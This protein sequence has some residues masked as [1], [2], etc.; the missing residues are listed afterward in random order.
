MPLLLVLAGCS[1]QKNPNFNHD[2][3]VGTGGGFEETVESHSFSVEGSIEEGSTVCLIVQDK[4]EELEGVDAVSVMSVSL[5][6]GAIDEKVRVDHNS[7]LSPNATSF[8]FKDNKIVMY[9]DDEE[10]AEW[11]EFDV[12][13][14]E[15]S[16]TESLLP[17]NNQLANIVMTDS[18]G[19]YLVTPSHFE[20]YH[21]N[22][23]DDMYLHEPVE[24]IGYDRLIRFNRANLYEGEVYSAMHVTDV[25]ERFDLVSGELTGT[26][27]LE[28]WDDW[29][30]GISVTPSGIHIMNAHSHDPGGTRIARFDPDTGALL[31]EVYLV[32]PGDPIILSLHGLLCEDMER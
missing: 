30:L 17:Y 21:Y 11:F 16:L 10:S 14:Q 26:V 29:V 28:D 24:V 9:S 2:G 6:D 7:G 3:N 5:K 27:L 20:I 12:E 15:L 23:L 1:H 13:S 32:R 25:I 18:D 22:T 19:W 31:G 8:V 4:D